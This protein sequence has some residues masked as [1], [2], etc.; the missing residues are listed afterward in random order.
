MKIN[1]DKKEGDRSVAAVNT[2]RTFQF[3]GR[4]YLVAMYNDEEDA[5]TRCYIDLETG[6]E[7]VLDGDVQIIPIELQVTE[8]I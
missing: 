5:A 2:G 6:I 8:I 3:N 1:V 7:I 4:F